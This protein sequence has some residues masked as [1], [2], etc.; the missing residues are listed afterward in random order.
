MQSYKNKKALKPKLKSPSKQLQKQQAAAVEV[1]KYPNKP[2]GMGGIRHIETKRRDN[3]LIRSH[4]E[5]QA[6]RI[7][8]GMNNAS[9]QRMLK[10]FPKSPRQ[11]KIDSMNLNM[12]P[13]NNSGIKTNLVMNLLVW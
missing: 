12:S 11:Q 2:P 8:G 4:M 9:L 7:P 5:E 1:K 3:K 13:N 10:R 6:A